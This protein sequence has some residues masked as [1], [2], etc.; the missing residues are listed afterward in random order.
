MS[1]DALLGL[2]WGIGIGLWIGAHVMGVRCAEAMAQTD[3]ALDVAEKAAKRIKEL[4]SERDSA[5]WWKGTT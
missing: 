4:E 1:C 5:D 2:S 3:R